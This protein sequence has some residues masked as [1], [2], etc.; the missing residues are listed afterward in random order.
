MELY[1]EFTIEAAHR[2]PHVPP[3]HKCARLHGHSFRLE[4]RVRG[5]LD[6]TLGWVMDFADIKAA[7]KPLYDQLDH[8]YLNDIPGL[9]NPTSEV[10]AVWI[11]ERL[12]PVLPLLSAVV[13]RETCTSGCEYRGAR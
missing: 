6:P 5:P 9:E 3:G 2:L 10:L 1:K 13:V 7:F 11:W 12:H 8:H 4:I